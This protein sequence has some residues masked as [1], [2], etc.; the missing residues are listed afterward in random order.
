MNGAASENHRQTAKLPGVRANLANHFTQPI[1]RLLART[2][3]TPT[4]LTWFGFIITLGAMVLII[5]GYL[6][7]AGFVVLAGSLFDMLDGAL[8]RHTQRT[9]RFGA[10]L[11]SVLDRFSEAALLFGILFFFI[12]T[13][14]TVG[15]ML[16]VIALFFSQTVSYI[17]ARTEALGLEG[18]EGLFT[19]PERIVVLV[20]G[21]LLSQ[22]AYA[23]FTAVA[24]IAVFSFITVIQRLVIAWQQTK[25]PP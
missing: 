25:S 15:I 3:I 10:V 12:G 18:K 24:I 19:R 7:A 8:A 9:T 14:D 11:D 23:L 13:Q 22:F 2:S 21:L 1:V 5:F 16:V 20:L 6:F 17:R 4:A